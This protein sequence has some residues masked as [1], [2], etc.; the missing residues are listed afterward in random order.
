MKKGTLK[1]VAVVLAFLLL[2]TAVTAC[3]TQGFKDW[4]PYGWFDSKEECEHEYGEDG[5]CTKCGEE[6]PI[7]AAG[8]FYIA[9][10]VVTGNGLELRMMKN[11]RA[12]NDSADVAAQNLSDSYT[13]TAKLSFL[14]TSAGS[15]SLTWKIEDNTDDAITLNVGEIDLSAKTQTAE[16]ICNKAFGTQKKLI[17]TSDIGYAN[18]GEVVYASAE[19]TLDYVKRV[20]KVGISNTTYTTGEASHSNT[21]DV[22]TLKANP[23]FGVGTLTPNVEVVGGEIYASSYLKECVARTTSGSSQWNY[24]YTGKVFLS[25]NKA[26]LCF[27]PS[28]DKPTLF[29][30]CISCPAG[31]ETACVNEYYNRLITTMRAHTTEHFIINFSYRSTYDGEIIQNGTGQSTGQFDINSLA[32]NV[33]SISLNTSSIIF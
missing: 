29:F 15:A 20:T 16:L 9:G 14:N 26:E 8:G 22:Y 21:P 32:A 7:E 10:N 4:N 6:K 2:G 30:N 1:T 3:M 31:S 27:Y 18:N 33:T 19:L 28:F 25:G 13:V 12:L 17:V 24:D 23:T 5:K 11:T